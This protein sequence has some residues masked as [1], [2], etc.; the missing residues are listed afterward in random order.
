LAS[1]ESIETYTSK[2]NIH[3]NFF[4]AVLGSIK[5]D[6]GNKRKQWLKNVLLPWRYFFFFHWTSTSQE[7][8]QTVLP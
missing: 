3:V 7:G 6:K 1:G 2:S 5:E 4:F 8:D